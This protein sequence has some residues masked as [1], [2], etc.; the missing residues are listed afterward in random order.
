M[1][2]NAFTIFSF[3]II[4]FVSVIYFSKKKLKTIETT[5][6]SWLL[7]TNLGMLIFAILSYVTII[8][9][10]QMPILN[11]FVSKTLISG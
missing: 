2:N 3:F 5:L 4:L 11:N 9:R 8:Y 6:Y 7:V 10:D 1:I